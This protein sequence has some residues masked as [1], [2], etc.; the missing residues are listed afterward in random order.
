MPSRLE[1]RRLHPELDAPLPDHHGL[2][3]HQAEGGGIAPLRPDASDLVEGIVQ[4]LPLAGDLLFACEQR[5]QALLAVHLRLSISVFSFC[6]RS[7]ASTSPAVLARAGATFPA[8]LHGK[9]ER[10]RIK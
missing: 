4:P 7:L 1:L 5:F 3:L 9:A 10:T 2:L 6:S 8:C